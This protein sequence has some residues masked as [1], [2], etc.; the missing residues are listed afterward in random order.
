MD[1]HGNNS[2][3]RNT[4]KEEGLGVPAIT[5]S[6]QPLQVL[7]E[8][9]SGLSAHVPNAEQPETPHTP[10]P[11]EW[12][13][14]DHS[15]ASLISTTVEDGDMNPVMSIGPCRSCIN[16]QRTPEWVWGRCHVP[17]YADAMLMK[18]APELLAFAQYVTKHALSIANSDNAFNKMLEMA[19]DVVAKA[20]TPNT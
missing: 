5:P 18:A 3:E 8:D 16:H 14:Q 12:L 11:W 6:G 4:Y 15:M 20:T 17:S 13:L 1:T 19:E 7:A 9:G 2:F 10:G